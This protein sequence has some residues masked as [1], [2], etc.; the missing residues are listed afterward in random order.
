MGAAPAV[1]A[2][3]SV[4]VLVLPNPALAVVVAGVLPN[5]LPPKLL[6][7]GAG[8]EPKPELEL[9]NPPD[10]GAPNAE[11]PLDDEPNPPLLVP[12]N[13]IGRAHV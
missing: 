12:P 10:E 3:G 11:A 8:V 13:Q 9:P 5:P 6:V 7:A 4:A 1:D 2:F